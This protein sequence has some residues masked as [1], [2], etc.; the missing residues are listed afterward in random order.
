M[1]KTGGYSYITASIMVKY[2]S[3]RRATT[4]A[5]NVVENTP[6]SN[7][8]MNGS[9]HQIKEFRLMIT[10]SSNWEAESAQAWMN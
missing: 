7:H 8:K 1:K 10:F 3:A 9:S 4:R 2:T 6:L 5:K